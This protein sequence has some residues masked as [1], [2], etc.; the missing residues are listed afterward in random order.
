VA[1]T[2]MAAQRFVS[3]EPREP[4]AARVTLTSAPWLAFLYTASARRE[5]ELRIAFARYG[6]HGHRPR[7][8]DARMTVQVILLGLASSI[9]PTSVAAVYAL[10]SAD[11][12]RRLMA[13]YVVTGLA[14]TVGF[15]LLAIFVFSSIEVSAGSERTKGIAEIVGG[16]LVLTFALGVL[17]G[18]VGEGH[19]TDAPEPKRRW[20]KLHPRRLTVRIAAL[21]GPVTHIPGIFYLIALNIIIA[22]HARAPRRLLEVLT[23]NAIWFAIPLCALAVCIVAPDR[24][25]E[26]VAALQRWTREHLRAILLVVSFGLGI[27]LVVTG[28]LTI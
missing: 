20:N 18:R 27:A 12:P 16:I 28:T 26:S 13:V 5:A 4:T 3:R 19:G 8:T 1:A 2:R 22:Y 14:F 9:R 7:A 17:T 21:A 24:A 15:G 10:L 25:R 6:T 11:A 23:Y